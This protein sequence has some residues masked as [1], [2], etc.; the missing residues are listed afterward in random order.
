MVEGLVK[1]FGPKVAVSDISFSVPE[2][3]FVTLLGPSGC[4]KSTTLRL[5]AGLE[6]PD[7]GTITVRGHL[8]NGPNTRVPA[9]KRNMGFVFQSYAL[10][11]H[12]TAYDQV[13]Y[14]LQVRGVP[15]DK[16]RDLVAEV[17]DTV[18]LSLETTRLP[19]E[20]S[21]GQQQRVALARALVFSPDIL[22][23]D[24]PLSNLDAELRS[25]MR[26][27]LHN[28]QRRI[29]VTTVYVTHDQLEALS[30][31]DAVI[32]M[33][34]G[35]IR[36]AGPPRQ[37]YEHPRDFVTATFVGGATTIEGTIAGVADGYADLLIGGAVTIRGV[38][39]SVTDGD[40]AVLSIKPEDLIVRPI[41]A[42]PF[43]NE[44]IATI[45]STMY[46]GTHVQLE[47]ALGDV[48]V[49]GYAPKATDFALGSSVRI[50]FPA[51]RVSIFASHRPTDE[52]GW[53]PSDVGQK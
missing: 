4:G 48:M 39:D 47:L 37:I 38:S 14:P 23:L 26:A 6:N 12:M 24:E 19:S 53:S 29:K 27:E 28:L 7:A 34:Q 16:V 32:V 13:A 1:S 22:L 15:K 25:Q 10:W 45:V 21:G 36:E 35:K 41:D 2:G 49:R 51:E 40:A 8:V 11:P 18:G 43:E 52:T 9:E 46:F 30:L 17:L 5:I 31:S 50:A 20:L 44:A 3:S 33:D 42:V